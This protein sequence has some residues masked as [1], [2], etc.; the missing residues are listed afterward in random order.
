MKNGW[1]S[2]PA[3]DGGEYRLLVRLRRVAVLGSLVLVLF[4]QPPLTR[5]GGEVMAPLSDLS[6]LPRWTQQAFTH[7]SFAGSLGGVCGIIGLYVLALWGWRRW[8]NSDFRTFFAR[9]PYNRW[10]GGLIFFAG[11][12]AVLIAISAWFVVTALSEMLDNGWSLMTLVAASITL[13]LW[14][15]ARAPGVGMKWAQA[16]TPITGA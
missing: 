3:D 2:L 12:G 5:L 14:I 9:Q 8:E 7:H 11:T 6:F 4:H 13:A 1:N 15:C 16:G 10:G